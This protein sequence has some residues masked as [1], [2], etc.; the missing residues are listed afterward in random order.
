MFKYRPR[1]LP[2]KKPIKYPHEFINNQ[3]KTSKN[4]R[5]GTFQKHSTIPNVFRN[6]Q[7]FLKPLM[8]SEDLKAPRRE[9]LYRIIASVRIGKE[10]RLLGIMA[11]HQIASI[12]NGTGSICGIELEL[13]NEMG[14]CLIMSSLNW[15]LN[16]GTTCSA[17][18][19]DRPS[20]LTSRPAAF[21]DRALPL[22]LQSQ[23]AATKQ[24]YCWLIQ[25]FIS[26]KNIVCF[27]LVLGK[28]F[29]ARIHLGCFWVPQWSFGRFF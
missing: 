9:S 1:I 19:V 29:S 7:E 8:N 6:I 23:P 20:L 24:T 14:N 27:F 18:D 10:T 12:M 22:L 15:M 16:E 11:T 5:F 2:S 17:A 4:T 3:N 21:I 25:K 26:I 28:F 13:A